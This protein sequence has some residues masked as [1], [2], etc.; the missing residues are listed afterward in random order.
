MEYKGEIFELGNLYKFKDFESSKWV[1]GELRSVDRLGR[2]MV[3]SWGRYDMIAE[4]STDELG[5]ITSVEKK[6]E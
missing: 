2:Y 6:H 4:L 5:S 3:S 1:V